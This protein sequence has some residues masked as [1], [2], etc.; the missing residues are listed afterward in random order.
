MD[1]EAKGGSGMV[2]KMLLSSGDKQLALC[3]YVPEANKSK[4][5][6]S[7]WMKAVLKEVG[8]DFLEGGPTSLPP[9]RF[10]CSAL[11]RL[12]ACSSAPATCGAQCTARSSSS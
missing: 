12:L 10:L 8:G 4:L 11:P 1:E 7:D 2:G 5:N 9:S 6:A 3:C